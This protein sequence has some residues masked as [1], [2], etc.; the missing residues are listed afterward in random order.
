MVIM[1]LLLSNLQS[2][3]VAENVVVIIHERGSMRLSILKIV[4]KIQLWAY[5]VPQQLRLL[6]LLQLHKH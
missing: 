6:L 4:Y 2:G 5:G 3:V 1:V